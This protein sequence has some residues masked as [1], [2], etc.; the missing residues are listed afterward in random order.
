MTTPLAAATTGWVWWISALTGC[1][2][3]VLAGCLFAWLRQRPRGGPALSGHGAVP[4]RRCRPLVRLLLPLARHS[5]RAE[6]R[7]RLEVEISASGEPDG[8]AAVEVRA[9]QWLGAIVPGILLLAI[10]GLPATAGQG[11]LLLAAALLGWWWPRLW[12]R[13][14][15]RR[16]QR[17]V[18]RALPFTLDMMTLCLEGGL[19]FQQ[20]VQQV[21]QR[22]P[23]GPLRDELARWLLDVRAGQT[24]T[25]ALRGLA[26]RLSLS[27]VR[28]WVQ[29]LVQADALGMSLGP[30][31][32]AQADQRRTERFLRAEKL[33]LQAPVKMLLPLILCIFPC[34]FLVIAFPVAMRMLAYFE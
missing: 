7:R 27:A 19:H 3:A 15:V 22:G 32:R 13:D 2:T 34:T 16:R 20:A 26:A 11:S 4:W 24:R 23:A 25:E 17:A 12:L 9:A 8:V 14:R 31:L 1:A 10:L 33:A 18:L 6:S 30:V 21:V 5:L 29:V 28:Q